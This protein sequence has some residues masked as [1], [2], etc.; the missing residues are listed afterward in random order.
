MDPIT[1]A[2]WQFGITTVYHWIQVPLTIGLSV[3]V[4]YMQT[5]A[6]KTGDPKWQRITDFF[7]KILLINF[8]LGVATGIVQEFQFGLNWSEYSRFVGDIFGAPLAFE[9]LLAFFLESTFLGLWIFG[10][11]RLSPKVHNL[12]IWLFSI[13]TILSAAFILAANS[14]MQDPQGAVFNPTTGRAELDGMSGFLKLF[15]T[16]WQWTFVHTLSASLMLSGI[17]VA[18]FAI[19]WMAR[20]IRLTGNESE[21]REYW[22]PTAKIGAWVGLVAAI[23]AALSGHFMGQHL[24][25]IQPTKAAAM[26]GV[27]TGEENAKLSL[28]MWGNNCE[29][30]GQIYI[31]IPGLESFMMTN[32][33]TG[34]E[35]RLQSIDEANQQVF[36]GIKQ[37]ENVND[38]LVT[39]FTEMYG[40]DAVTPNVLVSYYS[41]RVMVGIGLLGIVITALALW[42]LR[43]DRLIRSEKWGTFWL[44]MVPLPFIANSAGWM[45]TEMGRQ[46]WVVYP[47]NVDGVLLL[48]NMGVSHSVSAASVAFSLTAFTLLYGALGVCWFWLLSRYLKEG[49]NT[50]KKVIEYDA[51]DTPQFVY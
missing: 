24:G 34:P 42:A 11:G 4:A 33:F 51:A 19:W 6:R 25:N 1:L 14:F 39:K 46:P 45:L 21:A 22:K 32:H 13:G 7:G 48:T 9:A 17:L 28:V 37:M 47:S 3:I 29:E 43:G 38:E 16:T 15:G 31:P 44:W 8:A 10:K 40:E 12:T 36:E 2:R 23:V 20:S 49:I 26:M 27:C 35:S 50:H 18:G 30:A 5:K 41:F